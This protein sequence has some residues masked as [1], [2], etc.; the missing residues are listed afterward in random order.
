MK[1][2]W[3]IVALPLLRKLHVEPLVTMMRTVKDIPF[4]MPT[5]ECFVELPLPF[6]NVPTI[7]ISF[8]V[9]MDNYWKRTAVQANT[10]DVIEK[11]TVS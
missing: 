10:M 8:R 3:F 6:L 2:A 11:I 7:G 1:A 4:V 5:E 9:I